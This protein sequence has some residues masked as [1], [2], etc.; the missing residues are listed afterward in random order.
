MQQHGTLFADL[1]AG[2]RAALGRAITLIESERAADHSRARTLIDQCLALHIGSLR[3]G[4]TGIPGVGK[5]TFI[6]ALGSWHLQQGHRVAVLAIDPSSARSGGSIL[7]DKTRMERLS[8]DDRA[9]VRPTAAAGNLGGVGRRTRETILLCETA[10]YDRVII[11]TVGTGQNELD[12]DG[13]CDVNV[14]LLLAGAGDELQGI[15]RGI[16]ESA[17]VVA[18]TKVEAENAQRAEAARRELRNALS[19]LPPRPSGRSAE[20]FLTSALEG[21]GIADVARHIEQLATL[22]RASGQFASRR[23]VQGVQWMEQA[24]RTGIERALVQD[25]RMQALRMRLNDEVMAGKKS[26]LVAADELLL[27]FRTGA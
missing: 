11:E 26:P 20:V 3:I 9:F 1:R 18:F 24:L 14:L 17:D 22:D 12:V 5:S 27:R 16:M 7:G 13:L 15:K 23:H 10:G 8:V 2:D 4:I 21:A 19:L 25:E 6:D